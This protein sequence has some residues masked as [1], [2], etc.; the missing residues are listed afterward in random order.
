MIS[1]LRNKLVST[2]RCE[3]ERYYCVELVKFI[4]LFLAAKQAFE[5]AST[6]GL[7]P[8]FVRNTCIDSPFIHSVNRIILCQLI[9]KSTRIVVICQLYYPPKFSNLMNRIQFHGFYV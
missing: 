4:L 3:R 8:S 7:S 1:I 6:Y 9:I 5:P 2:L